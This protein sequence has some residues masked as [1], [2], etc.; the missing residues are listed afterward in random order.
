MVGEDGTRYPTDDTRIW[1]LHS[2]LHRNAR[3]WKEPSLFIPERFLVGPEDPLYPIKGA[4]RPFEHGP[5]DCIGQALAMSML[6]I[7]LVMLIRT[8]NVAPAYE[9][10]DIMHGI[11]PE[12]NCRFEGERAYQIGQ[13]GAH[14]ADGFPCRITVRV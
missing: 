14:P 2:V 6:R 4:Y 13:A 8:F 12:R 3:Y 9:E 1:V 5:R 11:P 10:W 7:C